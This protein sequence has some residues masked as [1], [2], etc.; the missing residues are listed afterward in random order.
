MHSEE[1]NLSVGV[2]QH[3][4]GF[5]LLGRLLGLFAENIQELLVFHSLTSCNTLLL[6]Q[7][8]NEDSMGSVVS[9]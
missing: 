4:Q 1:G 2:L 9:T 5:P 6:D 3:D 7:T 8:W